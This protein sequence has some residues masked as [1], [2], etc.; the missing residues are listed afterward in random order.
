M[1]FL[2]LEC[3]EKSTNTYN[4]RDVVATLFLLGSSSYLQVIRTYIKARMSS[5]FGQV[6]PLPT[7]LTAL[8]LLNNQCIM[9]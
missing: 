3:L 4:G 1:D 8:E 6:L 5:N 7:E 9:F 2:A